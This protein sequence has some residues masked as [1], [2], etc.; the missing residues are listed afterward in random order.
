MAQENVTLWIGIS[1]ATMAH[2]NMKKSHSVTYIKSGGIVH[3]FGPALRGV[4]VGGK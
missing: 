2:V 3:A 1:R 4:T